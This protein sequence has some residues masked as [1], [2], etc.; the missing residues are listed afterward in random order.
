[1]ES[2]KKVIA[3]SSP[4]EEKTKKLFQKKSSLST[5]PAEH[6]ITINETYKR[7]SMEKVGG[8]S[9]GGTFSNESDQGGKEDIDII[10]KKISTVDENLQKFGLELKEKAREIE[11]LNADVL[12]YRSRWDLIQSQLRELQKQVNVKIYE[13]YKETGLKMKQESN[14]TIEMFNFQ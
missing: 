14:L 5:L 12:E 3:K 10:A 1:M 7:N 9:L 8:T 11:E 2:A 4:R 13:I 6:T